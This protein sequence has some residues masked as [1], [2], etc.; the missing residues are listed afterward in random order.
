[1]AQPLWRTAW[2]FLNELKIK[3]AYN[4]TV[5]FL[6]IDPEKTITLKDKCTPVIMAALG[7]I[8]KT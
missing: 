6:G 7:T 2:R 4:P 1:M 8:A 3:L 5:T